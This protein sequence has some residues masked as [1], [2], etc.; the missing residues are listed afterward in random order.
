M[1][2]RFIVP[3]SLA[4]GCTQSAHAPAASGV[5]LPPGARVIEL[6][7]PFDSQTPYWPHDPPWHFELKPI[8]CNN[9]PGAG[10]FVCMKQLTSIPEHGGTHVDAPLHFAKDHASV[11]KIPLTKL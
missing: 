5:R 10:F 11:D 6:T 3:V 2:S 9:V 7:H 4:L 8:F 1:G